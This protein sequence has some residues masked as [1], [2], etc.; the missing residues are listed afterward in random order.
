MEGDHS[1]ER[2]EVVTSAA[3]QAL[4]DQLYEQRVY[5]EGSILKPNMVLSGYDAKKQAS[6]AEIA[7]HTVQTFRRHVP[8]AVPGIMF[9]S[10]GQ[11][12]EQATRAAQRDE[13]ARSAPVGAVVL[14][15][16]RVAGADA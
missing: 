7:E 11:T 5:L 8:A 13:Q 3:L 1:I 2:S 9:L 10:G 14:V 12:D 4:Y 15:R 16:P 6:D